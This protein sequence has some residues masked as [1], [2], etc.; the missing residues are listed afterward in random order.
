MG[1]L[2]ESYSIL[3]NFVSRSYRV[4]RIPQDAYDAMIFAANAA[5]IEIR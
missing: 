4:Q 2:G 5:P 1:S 3:M